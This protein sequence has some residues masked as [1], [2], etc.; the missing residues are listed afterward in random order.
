MPYRQYVFG[1][2]EMMK[3][4][5]GLIYHL[6]QL[7]AISILVLAFCLEKLWMGVI[8]SLLFALFWIISCRYPQKWL[9][10][11]R[12][13]G[14][15]AI[16]V[17][18]LMNDVLPS[19]MIAGITASLACWELEDRLPESSKMHAKGLFEKNQLIWL[20]LT[21]LVGFLLGE[22]CL[23]IK[24]TIPFGLVVFISLLVLFGIFQLSVVIKNIH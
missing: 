12:L 15:L 1:K 3:N 16:S 10:S 6:C 19:L 4:H 23:V 5:I 9:S 22:T 13:V 20:G 21:C 18:G 7:L 14:Y 2:C 11:I 24:L 8:F 17:I